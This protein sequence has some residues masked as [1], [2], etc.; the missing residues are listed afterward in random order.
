MNDRDSHSNPA[1]F[2]IAERERQFR[3]VLDNID[4]PICYYGRDLVMHFVNRQYAEL[5]GLSE[6]QILGRRLPEIIGESVLD[7]VRAHLDRALT[8]VQVTYERNRSWPGRGQRRLAPR[9]WYTR[10]C[11]AGRDARRP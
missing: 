3:L 2:E 1:P 4:L 11:W 5:I 9:P 6:M 7:E 10:S 8:G